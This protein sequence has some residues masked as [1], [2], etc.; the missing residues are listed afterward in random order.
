[1]VGY[2]RVRKFLSHLVS[3]YLSQSCPM[4]LS[5]RAL[6]HRLIRMVSRIPCR[7]AVLASLTE[8]KPQLLQ[9]LTERVFRRHNE[10]F[11]SE[12]RMTIGVAVRRN[13]IRCPMF[14]QA[15]V[16]RHAACSL[17]ARCPS[18]ELH[19]N[20]RRST[21]ARTGIA[22]SDCAPHT[23]TLA[24]TVHPQSPLNSRFFSGALE[25]TEGIT[26]NHVVPPRI[27]YLQQLP[28]LLP[29]SSR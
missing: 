24:V 9:A 18:E 5:P 22:N 23:T 17:A 29:T 25:E 21:L 20:P 12:V 10:V 4:S 6:Q 28:A 14:R 3:L 19:G 26:S 15:L 11:T 2:V 16:V 27:P 1:M 8:Q 7:S 13:H